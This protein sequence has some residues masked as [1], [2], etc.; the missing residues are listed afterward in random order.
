M[1]KTVGG[2]VREPFVHIAR[3]DGIHLWTI[4]SWVQRIRKEFPQRQQRR[5]L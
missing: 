2:I 3:I 4:Q 1:E 5:F